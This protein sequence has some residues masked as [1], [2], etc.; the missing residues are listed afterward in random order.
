MRIIKKIEIIRFMKIDLKKKLNQNKITKG[1][2]SIIPD[3]NVLDIF[4]STNLD[5]IILDTE[6]GNFS[7]TDIQ[8][9]I[10]ICKLN[11][12]SPL[13]R[14]PL[15]D[16]GNL[17]SALDSGCEGIVF[18][19]ISSKKDAEKAVSLCNFAPRGERGFNPFTKFNKYNLKIK[20]NI[21]YNEFP[22]IICILETKNAIDNI[23]DILKIKELDVIYFGTYDLSKEYNCKLGS[24]KLNRIL[25]NSIK[26][27]IKFKKKVGL[28]LNSQN[29]IS[30]SKKYKINFQL[31]SVDSEIISKAAKN[32]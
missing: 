3:H 6:H 10:A 18:P 30:I 7:K 29:H 17:Q 13:V 23:E 2:W 14:V 22:I 31:M 8:K 16:P 26:K 20:K 25:I 32:L 27:V 19:K 9:S 11:N 15:F 21:F 4:S 12:C 24:P 1:I 28:M 5:F